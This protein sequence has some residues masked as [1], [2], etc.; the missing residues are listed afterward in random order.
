MLRRARTLESDGINW[1]LLA[2]FPL[3]SY[4]LG[5]VCIEKLLAYVVHSI[6]MNLFCF[7]GHALYRMDIPCV[8]QSTQDVPSSEIF[9]LLF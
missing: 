3:I 6:R 7:M 4:R 9:V 1:L 8:E 5:L 2:I